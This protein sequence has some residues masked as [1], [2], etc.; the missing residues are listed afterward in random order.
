MAV[1]FQCRTKSTTIKKKKKSQEEHRNTHTP[2]KKKKEEG[3]VSAGLPLT[4]ACA[5]RSQ[6]DREAQ[7]RVPHV[8]ASTPTVCLLLPVVC[9]TQTPENGFGSY[10]QA[11]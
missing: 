5:V 6:E 10:N 2:K 1:S 7:Q 3:P 4:W 9:F 8:T 11:S